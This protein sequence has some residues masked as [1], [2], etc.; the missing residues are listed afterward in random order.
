M[1][2]ENLAE[3]KLAAAAFQM[4]AGNTKK[5]EAE[6]QKEV[7]LKEIEEI[8]EATEFAIKQAEM[9]KATKKAVEGEFIKR[10]Q[11]EQDNR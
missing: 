4:E 3:M 5:S 8:K 2:S 7:I 10:H 11:Q 1:E 6:K 9:A